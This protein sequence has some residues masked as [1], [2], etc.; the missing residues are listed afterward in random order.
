[1][2]SAPVHNFVLFSETLPLT[3]RYHKDL[4][5]APVQRRFIVA[6]LVGIALTLIATVALIAYMVPQD[7][8]VVGDSIFVS[9]VALLVIGFIMTNAL[10]ANMNER[11]RLDRFAAAPFSWQIESALKASRNPLLKEI[12]ENRNRFIFDEVA[13][14]GRSEWWSRMTPVGAIAGGCTYGIYL[15]EMSFVVECRVNEEVLRISTFG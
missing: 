13:Q 1:M 7:S 14:N 12:G 4:V 3:K 6:G 15:H 5:N 9:V 10:S 8:Y 11:A 2:S